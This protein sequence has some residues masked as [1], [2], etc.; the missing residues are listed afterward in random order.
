MWPILTAVTRPQHDR[1]EPRQHPPRERQQT[2]DHRLRGS[3]C[4]GH[5]EQASPQRKQAG[6]RQGLGVRGAENDGQ[7]EAVTEV[8]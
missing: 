5:T 3:I 1:E 2:P 8:F 4:T 6:G 7:W